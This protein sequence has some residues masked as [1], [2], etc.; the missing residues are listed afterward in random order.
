MGIATLL[1]VGM[2]TAIVAPADTEIITILTVA[3][4]VMPIVSDPPIDTIRILVT[5]TP[6]EPSD[7]GEE[8]S[9]IIAAAITIITDSSAREGSRSATATRDHGHRWHPQLHVSDA[10]ADS[11]AVRVG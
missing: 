9:D 8:M 11:G 2:V 5:A 6:R 1:M 4:G 3:M 10:G 7:T